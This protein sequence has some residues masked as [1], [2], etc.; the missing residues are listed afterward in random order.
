MACSFQIHFTPFP[1]P[2]PVRAMLLGTAPARYAGF[3]W[4][5][6]LYTGYSIL[7]LQDR[8]PK[9]P[10]CSPADAVR[11]WVACRTVPCCLVLSWVLL[12]LCITPI[13]FI[14]SIF[15]L[16]NANIVGLTGADRGVP[17]GRQPLVVSLDRGAQGRTR[18]PQG[19]NSG[20][21]GWN[22]MDEPRGLP[23]GWYETSLSLVVA[24]VHTSG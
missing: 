23:S 8:L 1:K 5:L 2:S 17:R 21:T 9:S 11:S 24:T 13:Q 16:A 15:M 3:A 18:G 6:R 19:I 20:W 14:N 10:Q 4:M 12:A 22:P 7:C